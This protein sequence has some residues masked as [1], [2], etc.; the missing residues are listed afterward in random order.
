MAR[1][2]VG[3][4]GGIAAYKAVELARAAIKAGHL[5]RVLATP[6]A[7][8][9]VGRATF[10]GITGAPV[11]ITEFDRDP[12]RGAFPGEEP[13]AHLPI[14]HLEL[15]ERADA[16]IVAPA[17][18]NTIAKLAAGLADSALTTAFLACTAPRLIAPAMNDRMYRNPATQE[19]LAR[20][21]KRGIE[22]LEPGHGDL[23]S[24][25]EYGVGRLQEPDQ[26]LAALEAALE[27]GAAKQAP[28][29]NQTPTAT[30]SWS[31]RHVLVTAGGSREP[32]DGVRFIGNRSSG[33]MGLALAEAAL[34][35]GAEVT[36]IAANV[37]LKPPGD[38]RLVEVE[39]T[40]EL[41]AACRAEFGTA[42]VLVMAAAPA[43]FRPRQRETGKLRREAALNLELEPTEDILAGLA[44]TARPDQILVGFAAEMVAGGLERAREKLERKGVAMIV[45]NDVSDRGIGFDSEENEVTLVT[46]E[47]SR[48]LARTGKREI[49]EQILDQIDL[50]G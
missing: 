26:L 49:A 21:K 7:E 45:F 32:I 14:G 40:S 8:R 16:F 36:L 31:G 11:L 27:G 47:A 28:A 44:R 41:A 15:A 35:R 5:V 19:N 34:A 46:G 33:R 42:D 23:A 13:P 17:S 43:D 20:L 25:G 18:A 38:A 50:L 4:S 29:A 22:I 6:A 2:L 10:E 24:K 48:S 12:L 9:F 37:A 39:T 30:G 3:V 1:I